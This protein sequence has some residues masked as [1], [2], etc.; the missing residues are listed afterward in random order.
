MD[1]DDDEDIPDTKKFGK[2]TAAAD[3]DDDEDVGLGVTAQR[4][5]VT[6]AADAPGKPLLQGTP[7]STA[8]IPEKKAPENKPEEAKSSGGFFSFFSSKKS[9]DEDKKPL[10]EEDDIE[11]GKDKDEKQKE[12]DDA[13][14]RALVNQF[15]GIIGMSDEDPE[16][17]AW[18]HFEKHDHNNPGKPESMGYVAYSLQIWPKDKAVVMPV[19]IAQ[20]EPNNNPFLPPPVGRLKFSWYYNNS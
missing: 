13:E 20:L 7:S 4:S 9:T 1:S 3:S 8:P 18:I 5:I 16:D 14:L 19:G 15:K 12:E 11:E 2:K 10:L 17:S 6:K